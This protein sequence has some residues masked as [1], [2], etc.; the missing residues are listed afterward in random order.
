MS[1]ELNRGWWGT[2]E[3]NESIGQDSWCP[4]RDSI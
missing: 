4:D 1:D 3:K 2:E